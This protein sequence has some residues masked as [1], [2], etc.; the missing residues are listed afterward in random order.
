MENNLQYKKYT[1]QLSNS[2]MFH[3]SLGSKE[4]FH[5]NFLHWISTINWDLF[6]KILHALAGVEKFWWENEF[7]PYKQN[8]EVR[9]EYHHFD[10]S[11]YIL[12]S[13]KV[14]SVDSS[15]LEKKSEEYRYNEGERVV[16][17]WIPVLILENKMK[18]LPYRGQLV[19]Y[20]NKAFIE[21]RTGSR[22]KEAMKVLKDNNVDYHNWSAD[23][24][25]TFILLSLMD[26]QIGQGNPDDYIVSLELE[27]KKNKTTRKLIFPFSWNHNTYSKLLEVLTDKKEPCPFPTNELDQ[28]VIKDYTSFLASLCE[29]AKLWKINPQA[30]YRLQISPWVKESGKG[31]LRPTR[32]D[33]KINEIEEYKKL[34]IHDI[35]E[36]L[37]YDQLLVLLEN[38]LGG[39]CA[40][41]DPKKNDELFKDGIKVFTKSDY[42]H[43]VGIFEAQF[44]LFQNTQDLKEH[45][46]KLIIQVQGE[47]YCHMVICDNVSN[48]AKRVNNDKKMTENLKS[49]IQCVWD[50]NL[51]Y[52]IDDTISKFISIEGYTPCFPIDPDGKEEPRWGKYGNNNLYQYIDIPRGL[53]LEV[54]IKAIVDD[55]KSIYNW[56]KPNA[57][58][59][60]GFQSLP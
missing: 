1:D 13:E 2:T 60:T 32:Y 19:E 28:L 22:I 39:C 41:F 23:H 7:E 37:L 18:S 24:G 36:K 15:T 12:D 43:G 46:L 44:W 45:Y 16:Q 4:L 27:Y 38:K 8:I 58:P 34:R 30:L 53:T 10:L 5:S 52:S 49:K 54:V 9:R 11:I 29:L 3:M 31:N 26:S 50:N 21:W 6:L 35:H 47:R 17:K 51:L 57:L 20:T 56:Y 25:I 33:E 55:I 59:N 14:S 42:A 48:G 40:R